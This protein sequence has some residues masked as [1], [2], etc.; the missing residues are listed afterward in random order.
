MATLDRLTIVTQYDERILVDTLQ[1]EKY[2]IV[3]IKD[4]TIGFKILFCDL[5]SITEQRVSMIQRG[6]NIEMHLDLHCSAFFLRSSEPNVDSEYYVMDHW[7]F[8]LPEVCKMNRHCRGRF[9]G[10]LEK[11]SD[12]GLSQTLSV[13]ST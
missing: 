10:I 9:N 11:M 1:H 7:S 13:K 3:E 6:I 2:A 4:S 12:K 5:L 8:S